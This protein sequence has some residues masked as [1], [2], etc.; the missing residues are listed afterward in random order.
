M[1]KKERTN[2]EWVAELRSPPRDETLADLRVLLVRGLS[3]EF[4]D[5]E[6]GHDLTLRPTLHV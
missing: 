6:A 3:P 1:M 2:E 4:T 5:E